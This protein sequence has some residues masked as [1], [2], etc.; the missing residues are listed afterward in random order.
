MNI[1]RSWN[2]IFSYVEFIEFYIDLKNNIY[3]TKTF[4][5]IINNNLINH[6]LEYPNMSEHHKLYTKKSIFNNK[7]TKILKN[8]NIDEYFVSTYILEQ[9]MTNMQNLLSDLSYEYRNKELKILCRIMKDVLQNGAKC[10]LTNNSSSCFKSI[11]T[12]LL[13]LDQTYYRDST[14]YRNFSSIFELMIYNNC[15]IHNSIVF[16]HNHNPLRTICEEI[17]DDNLLSVLLNSNKYNYI[18]ILEH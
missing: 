16:S 1:T 14:D 7:Y 18:N 5:K 9:I 12:E 8:I 17:I 10:D 15:D 11:L 2:N 4:Q 3:N 6:K 13:R